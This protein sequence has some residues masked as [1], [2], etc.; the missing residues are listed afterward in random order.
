M[1]EIL[2]LGNINVS[3]LEKEFGKLQTGEI[4]ITAERIAHIKERHLID[5]ELFEQY[6]TQCVQNPDYIVK[7]CK[8]ENTVFMI[9]KLPNMN[10]NVV[11]KL[12]LDTDKTDLKNSVMTF[13][14]IR[15][16]NLRKLIDK[17]P[18]LYRKE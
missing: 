10:L 5:Y 18:L 2:S 1:V 16:R 7:D 6:G 11:S 4:I 17:N 3:L 8:N 13:Y 14:R 15:E 9:M 12:A